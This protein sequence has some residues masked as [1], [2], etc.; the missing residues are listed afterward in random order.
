MSLFKW[1]RDA[2]Y[3][4]VLMEIKMLRTEL[5]ALDAELEVTKS[6]MRSLRQMMNRKLKTP[7]KSY[8]D[9]DDESEGQSNNP[10]EIEK[11]IISAMGYVPIELAEK[12]KNE[13][14]Q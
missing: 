12:Y 8:D 9:D 2:R 1:F 13:R 14:R 7:G 6:N 5:S 10:A 4:E 3:H 11:Q